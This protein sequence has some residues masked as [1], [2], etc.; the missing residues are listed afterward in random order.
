MRIVFSKIDK[1][2][3]SRFVGFL[4]VVSAIVTLSFV[5]RDEL[6]SEQRN[7]FLFLLLGVLIFALVY[8]I[9]QIFQTQHENKELCKVMVDLHGISHLYNE[10]IT[11]TLSDILDNIVSDEDR[12]L[13]AEKTLISVCQ[14]ISSCFSKLIGGKKC[15]V[16]IKLIVRDDRR[17]NRRD[18]T[19]RF[20]RTY[21]RSSY[22]DDRDQHSQR[23]LYE[24]G[25]GKNTGLD[26]A[27]AIMEGSPSHF[28][29]PDLVKL[30]EKGEY[31]NQRADFSNYYKSTIVVP[32]TSRLHNTTGVTDEIGFLSVDTMSTNRLNK[33]YH[34]YLMAA[35]ADQM[36]SFISFMKGD[37]DISIKNEKRNSE[38][39]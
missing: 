39:D 13:K 9:I 12:A 19:K 21:V 6:I 28:F 34:V 15:M 18:N 26:G 31:K 32:L 20:A 24:V 27:R 8:V 7:V 3:R 30:K 1:I 5:I 23:K 37:Y 25:A 22:V 29:S 10:E 35:F 36:F 14:K 16:T 11:K 38:D 2:T 17:D 4:V 33:K